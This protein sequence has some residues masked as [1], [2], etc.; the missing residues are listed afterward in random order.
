MTKDQQNL[1]S[2]VSRTCTVHAPATVANMVCGFDVL[3]MCLDQPYDIMEVTLLDERKVIIKSKD[4][5]NLPKDPALNTAGAP[6]LAI[7]EEIDRP[8]GFEV[9]IK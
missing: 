1:R 7:L 3:G 8:M 9:T 5:Y 6:L 2:S 4:G